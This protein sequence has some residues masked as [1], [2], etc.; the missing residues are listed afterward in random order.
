V[1]ALPTFLAKRDVTILFVKMFLDHFIETKIGCRDS[2]FPSTLAQLM[3]T[4][5]RSMH[6]ES[7]ELETKRQS[8]QDLQVLT[9]MSLEEM[10]TPSAIDRD[11]AIMALGEE[12]GLSRLE[13]LEKET[14]LLRVQE[15]FND[16]RFTLEPL[17]EYLA[18][19]QL[20]K[21]YAGHRGNWAKFIENAR[22]LV[23]RYNI[24]SFLSA[25]RDVAADSQ[26]KAPETVPCDL[27]ELIAECRCLH[28]LE[29]TS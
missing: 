4:Y 12:H 2:Q 3:L 26:L 8:E 14:T 5:V 29:G 16:I 11:Q 7:T 19:F 21:K 17:V 13:Y 1:C 6:P 20:A 24:S 23:S 10:F 27:E 28:V 9:L 15:G 18:A 22:R 25:M